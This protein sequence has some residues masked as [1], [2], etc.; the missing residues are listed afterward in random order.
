MSSLLPD[1]TINVFRSF[2]DMI[3]GLIGIQCDL[4]VPTN[5]TSLESDDAYASPTELLFTPY[6]NQSVWVTW[7][8][9]NVHR[10]RK[11]GTFAEGETPIIA[12]FANTPAITLHSYIKVPVRYIPGTFDTT[13]FEVVDVLMTNTYNAEIYRYAKLAPLRRKDRTTI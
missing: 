11:L 10:L 4:Y 12:R 7:F 8:E 3:I 1:E 2:N 6:P 5:L 13:E 9:K